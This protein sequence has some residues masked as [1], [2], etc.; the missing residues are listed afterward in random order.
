[1]NQDIEAGRRRRGGPSSTAARIYGAGT[2]EDQMIDDSTVGRGRRAASRRPMALAGALAAVALLAAACGGGSPGSRPGGPGLAQQLAEFARC[3]RGHGEPNFYYANPQ[4]NSSPSTTGPPL[5]FFGYIVPGIDPNVPPFPAA[6]NACE[7][8][9]PGGGA[10][11]VSQ[12]Q[13]LKDLLK[14]TA[15]MRA[16]GFPDFPDPEVQSGGPV[17]RSLPAGINTSSP[18]FQAAQKA[19]HGP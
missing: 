10:A 9:L 3:M 18:Q 19:C 15:C 14:F 17:I 11:P 1:V 12:Q 2:G 6:M 16:H 8:L 4:S 13:Q 5:G 7:H